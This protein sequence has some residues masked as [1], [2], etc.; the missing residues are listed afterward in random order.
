VRHHRASIGKHWR[1]GVFLRYPIA[2]YASEALL[3]LRTPTQLAVEVRAPSPDYFFN[4][5][6]DSIEDLMT[7]RWP[8][9]KYELHI[10]CPTLTRDGSPC[11]DPI[12][13]QG[14]VAYREESE[15]HYRCMRCR[16]RHD[17]SVLLTGFSQPVLSLQPELDRLHAEVA[18]VQSGINGLRASAAD[19]ADTIRRILR[20]VTTEITDCPRLFTL[21]LDESSSR[22]RVK[23]TYRLVLWCEHPGHWHPWKP[24]SYT[25]VRPQEWIL[26]VA[27][28]A[29]LVFRALQL[30]APIASA[31]AG[32]VLTPDQ[33][34]HTQ[35]ELT[36][37]TAVIATLP[38]DETENQ[39]DLAT[40]D[41][42]GQISPAQGQAWRAARILI[43]ENDPARSFGDLRRFQAPSGEFLWICP[44][45]YAEYDPGLP[46]IPAS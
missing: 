14:L 1:S 4:V 38:T 24:A 43:F 27:P 42:A 32:V 28:Y 40:I 41:S 33:L 29:T 10:P 9:L 37:M 3:E 39:L 30:L 45:H 5:L 11:A 26:Q 19:T 31:V 17:L 22:R 15:T 18:D 7:R 12:P 36:L 20:A 8:G 25:I 16:A 34:Q 21:A 23:M 6:R 44:G 2:A 35:N 46:N 13:M